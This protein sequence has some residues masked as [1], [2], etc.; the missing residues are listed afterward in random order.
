M[1]I[2]KPVV[3]IP[4]VKGNTNALKYGKAYDAARDLESGKSL[5]LE[6]GSWG[7]AR[8]FRQA[9][10]ITLIGYTLNQRGTT[11]YVTRNGS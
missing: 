10:R 4:P 3:G 5:P 9:G 1:K 11:V 6:F 2:G 8:T 7:E